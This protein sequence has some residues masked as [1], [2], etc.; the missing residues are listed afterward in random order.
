MQWC[1]NQRGRSHNCRF[2][3]SWWWWVLRQV[4]T[5]VCVGTRAHEVKH[6]REQEIP[7]GMSPDEADAKDYV[8]LIRFPG[9]TTLYSL[10]YHTIP[11]RLYNAR[12]TRH[13]K[14]AVMR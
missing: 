4:C 7:L 13:Y 1:A 11:Y 3:G 10:I 14:L 5:F 8:C 2:D 9:G 6:A 12:V